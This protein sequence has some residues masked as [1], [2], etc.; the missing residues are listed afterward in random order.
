MSLNDVIGQDRAVKILS[1]MIKREKIAASFLFS[2]ISGI[3]KRLTALEFAKAVNCKTPASVKMGTSCDICS[4]CRKINSKI[5]PDIQIVTPDEGII[6]IEQIRPI[7]EF[8]SFTPS[9][10]KKKVVIIDEADKMNPQASNAALKTLEE[11][12]SNSIIILVTSRESNLLDTIVSRCI[13]LTFVP[14]PNKAI[15]SIL[16]K[17]NQTLN[18]AQISLCRGSVEGVEGG[19]KELKR[20]KG[21]TSIQDIIKGGGIEKWKEREDMEEWFLTIIP[22]LRDMVISKIKGTDEYLINSDIKDEIKVLTQ[23]TDIGNMVKC[24]DCVYGVSAKLHLYPNKLVVQNYMNNVIRD[25][26]G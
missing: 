4:S 8:L 14:L 11:P 12:P 9:E 10:G 7:N 15:K 13:K 19:D 6:R 24:F 20:N 22:I 17:N 26:L 5:H 21:V 23:K 25:M 2:G 1:S 3:G 18:P 16:N